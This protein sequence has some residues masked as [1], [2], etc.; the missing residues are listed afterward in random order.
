MSEP[1]LDNLTPLQLAVL[2]LLAVL[3]SYLEERDP[4]A[5]LQQAL[6]MSTQLDSLISSYFENY[7]ESL[8]EAISRMVHDAF[9]GAVNSGVAE[10]MMLQPGLAEQLSQASADFDEKDPRDQLYSIIDP[11]IFDEKFQQA[12]ERVSELTGLS[13]EEAGKL[14]T[15]RVSE[16]LEK[17]K[18]HEEATHYG[19]PL[20]GLPPEAGE[21]GEA[22]EGSRQAKPDDEERDTPAHTLSFRVSTAGSPQPPVSDASAPEG[23]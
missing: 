14:V 5:K 9:A 1:T 6:K 22:I 8:K 12:S 4:S 2:R 20:E 7:T 13:E 11:L 17:A 21:A 16:L 18:E 19:N 23:E 10:S 3:E 15:S